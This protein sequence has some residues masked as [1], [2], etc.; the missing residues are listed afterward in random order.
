MVSIIPM[1][2]YIDVNIFHSIFGGTHYVNIGNWCDRNSGSSK[3][4][5]DKDTNMPFVCSHH[6]VTIQNWIILW[7]TW[8]RIITLWGLVTPYGY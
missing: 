2:I 6:V 1:S 7:S 4:D 3:E 8:S 5:K